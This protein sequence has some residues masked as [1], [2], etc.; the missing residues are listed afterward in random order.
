MNPETKERILEKL[1]DVIME[2]SDEIDEG[3]QANVVRILADYLYSLPDPDTQWTI[4]P[5][6]RDEIYHEFCY[7]L[8][9]APMPKPK[10]RFY[11]F[12]DE[13]TDNSCPVCGSGCCLNEL[14]EN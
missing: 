8:G 10:S 5:A 13:H 14:H 9:Y 12:L 6:T 4:T 2:Y 3:V 11:R 1:I 7:Q